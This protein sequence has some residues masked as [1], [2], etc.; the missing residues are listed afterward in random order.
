MTRTSIFIAVTGILSAFVLLAPGGVGLSG[1]YRADAATVAQ[2]TC[3]PTASKRTQ[4]T[5]PFTPGAS[6]AIT[7]P[8]SVR[9]QPGD[10]AE[11]VVTG[12]AALLDHVH[13]ENDTL[14]L[15]CELVGGSPA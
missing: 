5:L 15:D 3:A 11:A 13:I 9:Y 1:R 2:S 8:G 10:K 7:L 14:S 6:L 12:D 4:V